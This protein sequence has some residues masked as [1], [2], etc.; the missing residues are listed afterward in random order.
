MLITAGGP[1]ELSPYHLSDPI[2][3]N[4][5]WILK[6]IC[7][8]ETPENHKEPDKLFDSAATPT[9]F[10]QVDNVSISCRKFID[11]FRLSTPHFEVTTCE[12]HCS[13]H[14]QHIRN[15]NSASLGFGP[16]V[17]SS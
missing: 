5:N 10:D 3:V 12:S 17:A 8:P 2:Q 7:E 1:F 9:L 4:S 6:K 13:F 11:N 14:F 16:Q 15:G